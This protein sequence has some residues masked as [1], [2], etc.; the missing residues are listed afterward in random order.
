MLHFY[1]KLI[2]FGITKT[3]FLSIMKNIFV[4]LAL[5]FALGASAQIKK[6]T[7]KETPVKEVTAIEAAQ[8]DF[9]A[10]NAFISIKESSKANLVKLFETKHREIKTVATLSEE[11][12]STF[13]QYISG[14]L[15]M[16]LGAEDF[17]KVKANTALYAKLTK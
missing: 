12:K 13:S 11:R 17:A 9:D 1:L 3:N 5:F 6:T 10:L 14:R 16:L 4:A 2:R 15:E 7:V 8:K